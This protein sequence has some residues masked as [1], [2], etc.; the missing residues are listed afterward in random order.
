VK[1]ITPM[2]TG[3]LTTMDKYADA[4][5]MPGTSIIDATKTKES[6]KEYQT[7]VE[8]GSMVRSLSPGMVVCV[9]PK[10]YENRKYAKESMKADMEEYNNQVIGYNF[11]VVLIDGKQFLLLQ[12]SDIDFI[13]TE[14]ETV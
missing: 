3:V 11:P 1:K 9:N 2:F 5:Y 12:E 13:V 6:L 7:V 4:V 10:R 14:Y 8:V